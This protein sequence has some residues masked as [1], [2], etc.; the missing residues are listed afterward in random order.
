L[1][2]GC[3]TTAWYGAWAGLMTSFGF[4]LIPRLL[5]H[6][7]LASLESCTNL[8]YAAATLAVVGFWDKGNPPSIRTAA[9][10]GIVFGLALLTKIQAVIL[11]LPIVLWS[12]M[13][14]R[15]HCVVPLL[16][17]GGTACTVF[18]A[19]WPWLWL[20]PVEHLSQ[21]LHG[22][23]DRAAISVWYLNHKYTDRN[24]PWHYAPNYFCWTVPFKLQ[25]VGMVGTIVKRSE[26][27]SEAEL[28]WTM[29]S[30]RYTPRD[31]LILLAAAWPLW[32]FTIPGIPSYDCE[33]LWLPSIPL[34]LILVGRGS[35]YVLCRFQAWWP[36]A[37]RIFVLVFVVLAL[38]QSAVLSRFVA[39]PLSFYAATAGQLPGAAEHGLELNYW[40]DAVTRS[41][42]E[43][44]ERQ[45]PHDATVALA[46]VLHQFQAQELQIQSPIL[47]RH[48]VRI[49]PYEESDASIQ[50]LLIY[51]RL[52]DLPSELRGTLDGWNVLSE[53]QIDGVQ[54]AALLQRQRTPAE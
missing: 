10:T 16:V 27:Q 54:L 33:R 43:D 31:F 48:G 53:V 18:F 47:R 45:V 42:L 22:A 32:F 5:G 2:V 34:W 14:W 1:L 50:Y 25:L 30:Y 40:G 9:L 46:P 36:L 21:Y 24:V 29:L 20:D 15:R 37:A 49:V 38:I 7:H 19:G 35:A 23:T 52:A 4:V 13:R 44:V 41:L 8:T 26:P 51:R 17:W 6:A 28:R 11:P 39:T 12:F 3:C